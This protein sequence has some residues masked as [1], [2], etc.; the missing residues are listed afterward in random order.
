MYT[1]SRLCIH[2]FISLNIIIIK[3]FTRNM[4]EK[5]QKS[6]KYLIY[7]EDFR[8]VGLGRVYYI[9]KKSQR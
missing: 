2:I 7:I 8:I 6:K 5:W 9:K 4:P 1:T 3:T